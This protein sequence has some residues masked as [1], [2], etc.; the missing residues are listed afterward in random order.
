MSQPPE[1]F[2]DLERVLA[3]KRHETPPPGY[4]INFSA[5]IIARI[6]A[7]ELAGAPPWWLRLLAPLNWQRGLLGANILMVAGAGIVGISAYHAVRP[8]PEEDD[9]ALAT[10]PLPVMAGAV[11][12]TMFSDRRPEFRGDHGGNSAVSLAGF[13]TSGL[14]STTNSVPDLTPPPGLFSTPGFNQLQPRFVLPT[15]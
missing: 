3:W 8:A 7:G 2:S 15:R 4:F 9:V 13:T 1:D 6:E 5:K 12:E 11:N 10:L 14:G